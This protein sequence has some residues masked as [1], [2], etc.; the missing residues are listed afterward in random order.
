MVCQ[1][2]CFNIHLRLWQ[3]SIHWGDP[4]H[5][6]SMQLN[7]R[8]VIETD[9]W[10]FIMKWTSWFNIVYSNYENMKCHPR[11]FYERH[12]LY[13]WGCYLR[14]FLFLSSISV[15]SFSWTLVICKNIANKEPNISKSRNRSKRNAKT[16]TMVF[17]KDHSIITTMMYL[18]SVDRFV[19]TTA[20]VLDCV[21]RACVPSNN[22]FTGLLTQMNCDDTQ[23]ASNSNPTEHCLRQV[24]QDNTAASG[25][26]VEIN[27]GQVCN[28][29][30]VITI[31][32]S[33]ECLFCEWNRDSASDLNISPFRTILPHR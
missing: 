6:Q 13:L 25:G 12:M 17:N 11:W 3:C 33:I 29:Y 18:L 26:V 9:V 15:S 4:D 21:N 16:A 27:C 32:R 8:T 28:P 31:F 22:P 7:T 24:V 30:F 14:R 20:Q 23:T 19:L 2:L 1:C 5:Q 10:S